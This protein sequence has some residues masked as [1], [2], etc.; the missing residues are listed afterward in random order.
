MEARRRALGQAG[1]E[2]LDGSPNVVDQLCTG[3]DESLART[4][5][6]KVGLGLLTAVLEWVQQLGV[7]AGQAGQVLGIQL[8]SFVLVGIDE[9]EL[10][11][12]GNQDLMTAALQQPADPRRMSA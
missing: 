8:V 9:S 4:Q 7:E 2:G 3:T 5:Q 11:G 10:S 6:R 12:V 1:S